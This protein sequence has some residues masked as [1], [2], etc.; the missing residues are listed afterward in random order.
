MKIKVKPN[1][2]DVDEGKQSPARSENVTTPQTPLRQL[3]R[4]LLVSMAIGGCYTYDPIYI[5]KG[6]ETI[7]GR[8]YRILGRAYRT[9]CF[10]MCVVSCTQATIAFFTLPGTFIPL[11]ATR[12]IWY[13]Q[14]L[15]LSLIAFKSNHAQYGGQK[16]AFNLW[17]DK[18][19]PEM[20]A[21]GMKIPEAKIKKRQRVCV[22]S[23]A[24]MSFFNVA[25][26]IVF[27]ADIF[28]EG[29]GA[30]M[31]APFIDSIPTLSIIFTI[32]CF[33][34]F[35]WVM[36]TVYI[37]LLSMLL[38]VSFEVINEFLDNLVEQKSLTMTRQFQRVRLLHLNLCKMVMELDKD[39]GCYLAV[40]LVFGCGSVAFIL[41]Q[42]L[43][44]QLDSLSFIMLL[45]FI[46]AVMGLV[47]VSSVF[48]AFVNE[49]VSTFD[50]FPSI[51]DKRGN[52][53]DFLFAFRHTISHQKG[54]KTITVD[55][56]CLEVQG[57]L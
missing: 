43:R 52:L 10:V 44:T 35:I 14:C 40:I 9:I 34:T 55:S 21:L 16:K 38:T 18:I 2:M 27:S 32:Y 24:F 47:A 26:G 54:G 12:M 19:R 3:L 23:A 15:C 51:L 7:E 41:Y 31:S 29:Y 50:R 13:I 37:L 1:I 48:A 42:V 33:L 8:P 45:F 36:S 30:F 5:R 6:R 49:A 57:T 20:E 22:I 39:F 4:P 46:T 28:S 53:Y 17:D 56:R 25:T 11:N